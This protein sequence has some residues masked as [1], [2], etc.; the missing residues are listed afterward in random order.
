MQR[1]L[2]TG[3]NGLLGQKLVYLLLQKNLTNAKQ[4]QITAT[5]RGQNRLVNQKGYQ[6]HEL[7]I[8]NAAEVERIFTLVKPHIVINTAAMTNVDQCEKERKACD[9]LNVDAVAFQLS[10]L[11]KLQ[12]TEKNYKPHFIHL[13]TDFVFDGK[14]GPYS[15]EDQPNP[16]SY[17]GH[18]KYKADLLVQQSS[19]KWS[20]VRTIIVYG[21]VDNMSRSNLVLWAKNAL[22]KGEPIHVIND[23][24]RAPTLAEDLA[25]GCMLI[26]D[27]G[28]SGIFNI[29]GKDTYSILDLVYQVAD[30]WQLDKSLIQIVSS[31]TLNQPAKRPPRTG[32]KLDKA[33]RVLGYQPKSFRE[34]LMIVDKQLKVLG[35]S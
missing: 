24:F 4:Y 35:K 13:S 31:D 8:T 15:E 7:D 14:A 12:H 29:S 21:V 3:T 30:F 20:V 34:G 11:E 1:I 32:F 19:V 28:A 17:Y 33:I 2:I 27:K 18:S 6:Y 25:E 5:S 16:I 22:E 9:L 26:A 10:A 23:Q